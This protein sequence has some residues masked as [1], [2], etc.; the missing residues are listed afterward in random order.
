MKKYYTKPKVVHI[1]SI[2]KEWSN[3]SAA[4]YKELYFKNK[5]TSFLKKYIRGNDKWFEPWSDNYISFWDSLFIRISEMNNSNYIFSNTEE[6]LK[7]KPEVNR[8]FI[9]DWDICYQTASD[10]W[11]VNFYFWPKA[12][13]NSH[14]RK[15]SFTEKKF[16]L[17]AL[18][19][20]A[21]CKF[22]VES[23]WSI[24]WVD[25]FSERKFNK[26]LV[27]FPTENNNINPDFVENLVS[28]LV[29]NIIDKEYQ[30]RLKNSRINQL[31]ETELKNNQKDI[32]YEFKYP[33]ISDI[34]K[35]W[36]FDTGMYERK[37]YRLETLINNYK[38]GCKKLEE[39]WFTTR[40]WPN[41]AVSVIWKSIYS[42]KKINNNF[43][44]LILSKDID[45]F[46]WIQHLQYIWNK[47]RLPELKQFDILLFA[48]W[49]IG[50]VLLIDDFLIW[51]TSNFDVF[52]ISWEQEYYKKIFLLNFLKY[53]KSINYRSYLWV[54]G[55]GADSLT[56]YFLKQVNFPIFPDEKQKEISY[57]YYNKQPKTENLNFENYLTVEKERNKKLW[58]F[59]LNMELFSLKGKLED[60]I[61]K[62]IK[63][64]PIEINFNY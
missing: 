38:W 47:N 54:W 63:E 5:N 28:L 27:P 15:L 29:Q 61:D 12:F 3:F 41:L 46:W 2:V 48:R 17:F 20:S 32:N 42:E 62:I 64:E 4:S 59:Q 55:S 13:F 51:W 53:L 1:S 40:K 33:R 52:F 14:I 30:I 16:Y 7:I 37:F 57:E 18:L 34:R 49:N 8:S 11:N 44:Q 36:R 21:F 10:V 24:K 6:T 25:N 58:I 23:Q 9:E 22:Q 35:I 50:R 43:R 60:I 31:I 45:E 56:D 39:L 19:K 26:V